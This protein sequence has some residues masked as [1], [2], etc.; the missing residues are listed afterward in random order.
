[1]MEAL[2]GVAIRGIST[3]VPTRVARIADYTLL[4]EQEREKFSQ[5]TGIEERRLAADKQYSSD[6]CIAA[7]EDLLTRLGW[8]KEGV[9]ALVMITQSGDYPIPA[10]SII[11]QHKL[12]LPKSCAA[13]DVN[14]GCSSYPYGIAILGSMMR[15]LGLTRALLL[16]GDVSSRVC[17]YNDKSSWP[18]FGDAGSATALELDDAAEP[19]HF[20]LNS[21]G[22]GKDAIIVEA[23]GLAARHPPQ[24]GDFEEVEVSAGIA[25]NA[26]QLQLKGADIF[27]F[28]ISAVPP[29]IRRV[30]DAA[31][32][33]VGSVDYFVLHQANKMINDMIRKKLGYTAEHEISTLRK[34][35]NTS[36]VSVPLTLTAGAEQLAQGGR[37][38]LCGFGVGLS[39]GSATVVFQPGTV[40]H[41][42]E[43]DHV[44]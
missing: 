30:L 4:T 1:M 6:L 21:D 25:R 37:V 7:A 15:T 39:W 42:F 44:Y 27:S 8:E 24:P 26:F 34:Y 11:I 38:L 40:L 32:W 19:I 12:G 10:T 18:L 2:K 28:A 35:G 5:G 9:Q 13:F 16:V 33:E 41:L 36:S 23:G 17:S 14:L 20:D 31:G 3:A 29:S 22:S 43:S